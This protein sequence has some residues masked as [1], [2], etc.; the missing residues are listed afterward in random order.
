MMKQFQR[1][2]RTFMLPI[3]LLP[4]AGLMLGIGASFTGEAFVSLYHLEW[5]LG[6]G[7]ILY[8]VLSVFKDAGDVIFTNLPLLFAV[9]VALGL[10]KENKEVA[11]LSAVVAYLMMYASMT[12]AMTH[13]S[14]V[15]Q[16]LETPGLISNVLGFENT[17]NMGVF[18]GII[19]GLV[20]SQVHNKFYT[21]KLPDA[22]SFFSGTRFVPIVSAFT[23]VLMGIG[24]T[25]IWPY[26]GMGIA[27]LGELVAKL[28]YVGTFIYGYVYRA[29]IPL[30]LHHVFYLPFWQTALGGVSEV[31]GVVVEGAQNIVFA[32]L[33]AGV[34]V[35]PEAARF[36]TGMFPFMIFGFPAAA[37]AMYHTAR[38]NR[39]EDVKGLL[40][41][42]SLTSIFTGITEPIEFA[43]LF[44]SP[45]LYFGV[46]GI[47]AA[48]SFMIMHILK[49]GVGLTFSGGLLDLLLYGVLPGQAQTNWIPVVLV[50]IVYGFLYYGAFRFLI[51]KFDLKT[52]G[53]EDSDDTSFEEAHELKKGETEFDRTAAIIIEG[54][55]GLDNVTSLDSC[56][57]RLRLEVEDDDLVNESK[58]KSAKVSGVMRPGRGSVQVIIGP[59]VQFVARSF[60]R[61]ID[62]NK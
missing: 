17:M 23:A 15:E 49:A 43:F 1:L 21:I 20:I 2:G 6:E 42:S 5:L 19:V 31:S 48:S 18:G 61:K 4:V 22:L 44:A 56:A 40:V 27:K 39:K 28:G 3:A 24:F 57:T 11:A 36:F 54:L 9:G 55:G 29:L 33:S 59:D 37:L 13:F 41:S 45:L 58:I 26:A 16:L 53:R 38:D 34:T 47:L 12:S 35:D 32:Q 50:G 62:K 30:G 60:Q 52:P 25:W 8:S 14:N 51:V 46:H 10:A 7:T